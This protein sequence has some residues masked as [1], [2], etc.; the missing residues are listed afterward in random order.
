M[1][2]VYRYRW[3]MS[4][5]KAKSTQKREGDAENDLLDVVFNSLKSMDSKLDKFL[6]HKPKNNKNFQKRM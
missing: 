4:K 6:N 3:A 5:H 2:L 1:K